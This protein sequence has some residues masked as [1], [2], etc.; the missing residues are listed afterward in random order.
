MRLTE[1][2]SDRA[3][4][5]P[6]LH[7]LL[8][9][10]HKSAVATFNAKKTAQVL[11]LF[12]GWTIAKAVLLKPSD[13]TRDLARRTSFHQPY[14]TPAFTLES[15]VTIPARSGTRTISLHAMAIREPDGS[16]RRP[17]RLQVESH[18][19]DEAVALHAQVA[20]FL[21]DALPDPKRAKTDDLFLM[22]L[23][24]IIAVTEPDGD[25]YRSGRTHWVWSFDLFRKCQ[26]YTIT[27]PDGQS[28]DV[29]GP[30]QVLGYAG[31]Q[32]FAAFF[33]W[34]LA[35][36]SLED[37]VNAK[38]GLSR[39]VPASQRPRV[40]VGGQTIGTCAICLH[41]QVVRNNV[42]VAHG[43]QRPGHGYIIG[44]CFG[45][46]YPAYE[47]APA[48][49]VAYIPHLQGIKTTSEAYLARLTSGKVTEFSERK[50]NYRTNNYEVVVIR[51]Q[52]RAFAG[53]LQTEITHVQQQIQYVIADI[54]TMQ[55]RITNWTPGVLRRNEA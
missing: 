43:Y 22:N 9:R 16:D 4:T 31:T 33:K 40:P 29:C 10:L 49:C 44:E 47:T 1:I 3:D 6:V 45:V 8:L 53:M 28:F 30:V 25:T 14:E 23:S 55:A 24:E 2:V 35:N 32:D 46:G 50:R 20:K 41:A 38:L 19:E 11:S 42:M 18:A 48:A 54:A 36:T 12:T 37:D 5:D 21:V 52:D 39:H 15:G 27:A 34:A 13:E 26:G 7:D 17:V 51:Q